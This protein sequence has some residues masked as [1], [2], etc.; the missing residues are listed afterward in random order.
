MTREI[1]KL[2][3]SGSAGINVL[4]RAAGVSVQ[5]IDAGMLEPLDPHDLLLERRIGER[6]AQFETRAGDDVR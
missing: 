2:V 4:A 1:A 5:L 6:Y 3:L